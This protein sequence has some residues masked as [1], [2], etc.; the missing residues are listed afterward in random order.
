MTLN[1]SYDYARISRM[2][3]NCNCTTLVTGYP[4]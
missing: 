4:Y 2:D 3:C 1:V